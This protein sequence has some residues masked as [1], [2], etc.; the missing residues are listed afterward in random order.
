MP[1]T[2]LSYE[3]TPDTVSVSVGDEIVSLV[4]LRIKIDNRGPTT[5]VTRIN[6]EIPMGASGSTAG[7]RLSVG[8]L[9][10]PE[11]DEKL[12][13]MWAIDVDEQGSLLTI[14]AKTNKPTELKTTLEIT[15]PGIRVNDTTGIVT[16]TVDEFAPSHIKATFQINKDDNRPVQRFYCADEHGNELNPAVLHELDKRVWLKW[17]CTPRG[18][19]YSYSLRTEEGQVWEPKDWRRTG[20]FFS[21][22]DG[23]SGVQTNKLAETTKFAL[24]VI[25]VKGTSRTITGILFLKVEIAVPRLVDASWHQ[26]LYLSSTLANLRWIAVDTAKCTLAADDRIIDDNAPV[27]ANDGYNVIV[28]NN[29]RPH[30][31][32]VTCHGAPG[33]R[34]FTHSFDDIDVA[35]LITFPVG[36]RAGRIAITPDGTKALVLGDNTN[37]QADTPD[38]LKIFD[39]PTGNSAPSSV[40]TIHTVPRSTQIGGV[41]DLAITPDGTRA[42]AIST[43]GVSRVD[44]NTKTASSGPFFRTDFARAIA[45]VNNSL[46]L[47]VDTSGGVSK[48][49]LDQPHSAGDV[50][51]LTLPGIGVDREYVSIATMSNRPYA[52]VGSNVAGASAI[53]LD[54]WTWWGKDV[55]TGD[56]VMNMANPP[57]S[58]L[59]LATT[60]LGKLLVIEALK[61]VKTVQLDNSGLNNMT[62]YFGWP[63]AITPDGKM[64]LIV[65]SGKKRIDVL[66]ISRLEIVSSIDVGQDAVHVAITPDGKRALIANYDSQSVSMTA[67]PAD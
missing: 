17:R 25:H 13:D 28:A 22:A 15:L 11:Y 51:R 63:I 55:R 2:A 52:F 23:T 58:G 46:A 30:R 42:F 21:C 37:M 4:D 9:P 1:D 49:P 24:D 44:L 3:F 18:E 10:D 43:G 53:N 29:P 26:S 27:D 5:K 65:I 14:A 38:G 67:L 32:K 48:V 8:K 31:L 16:V 6:I 36:F 45:I 7:N 59:L 19:G 66:D 12:R 39:I 35:P 34:S 50:P 33:S 47:V 20:E 40:D 41:F 54:N 64:A 56:S 57:N 61:V 62:G 60:Y